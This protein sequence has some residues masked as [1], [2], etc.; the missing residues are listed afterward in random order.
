MMQGAN[1]EVK[2]CGLFASVLWVNLAMSYYCLCRRLPGSLAI[3]LGKGFSPSSVE[4]ISVPVQLV[5]WRLHFWQYA[6]VFRNAQGLNESCRQAG[7]QGTYS[8]EP[9]VMSAFGAA[10]KA[11][12]KM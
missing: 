6:F 8:D 2:G 9:T 1:S 12:V 4:A 3:V 7:R 5:G 11:Q 10:G